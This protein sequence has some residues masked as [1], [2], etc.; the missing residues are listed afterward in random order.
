MW[1]GVTGQYPNEASA[2]RSLV[3][4]PYNMNSGHNPAPSQWRALNCSQLINEAHRRVSGEAVDY[5]AKEYYTDPQNRL[6]TA[7]AADGF[8]KLNQAA[9]QPGDIM[10]NSNHV[11]AYVGNGE[12]IDS[13]PNHG[14]VSKHPVTAADLRDSWWKGPVKIQQWKQ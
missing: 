6:I 10:T 12:W 3:G 7:Q 11:A 13:D 8:G 1:S 5:G 4:R 14:G 2:L 9:L